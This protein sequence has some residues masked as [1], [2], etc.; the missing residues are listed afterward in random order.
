MF[1]LWINSP[2]QVRQWANLFQFHV[3]QASILVLLR[4]CPKNR[5]YKVLLLFL[6]ITCPEIHLQVDGLEGVNNSSVAV[7]SFHLEGQSGTDHIQ[8]IGTYYCSHPLKH[9]DI[10]DNPS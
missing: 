2:L 9:E 6:F 4:T 1:D 7:L 3:M 10:I 5:I 8:R